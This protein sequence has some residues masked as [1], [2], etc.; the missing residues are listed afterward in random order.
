MT[1][2]QT[3]F[4]GCM[5]YITQL[6]RKQY[7]EAVENLVDLVT[8][9]LS[10]K[11]PGHVN[12]IISTFLLKVYNSPELANYAD[13]NELIGVLECIKQE[14]YRVQV[15]NYEGEKAA[16]NGPIWRDGEVVW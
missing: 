5:P 12:F 9:N 2:P 14:I 1:F 13:W 3:V 11:R 10:S 6:E 15:S 16:L 7:K 8:H 4:G